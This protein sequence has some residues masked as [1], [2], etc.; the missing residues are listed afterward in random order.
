MPKRWRHRAAA[1]R[2]QP[3]DVDTVDQVAW[4][5]ATS[6]DAAIRDGQQAIELAQLAVR[7][8]EGNDP[9]PLSAL[10]AAYAEVGQFSQAVEMAQRAINVAAQRG[11]AAD[12]IRA[13]I[14]LYRA[15]RP[16]HGSPGQPQ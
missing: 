9:R 14:K 15:N 11:D 16:Y 12:N 13:Q 1:I 5:L 6:P 3:N 4:R 2:L 10:A 8:S 7:R